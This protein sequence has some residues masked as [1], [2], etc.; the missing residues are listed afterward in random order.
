MGWGVWWA[1]MVG[2][3]RMKGWESGGVGCVGVLL[4]D[5]LDV[6]VFD[7]S[8]VNSRGWLCGGSVVPC[9]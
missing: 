2:E 3:D 7:S 8:H 6:G 9:A 1:R 5:G 4:R